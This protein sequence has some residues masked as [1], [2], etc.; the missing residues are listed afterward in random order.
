MVWSEHLARVNANLEGVREVVDRLVR[1]LVYIV[2][3]GLT[4]LGTGTVFVLVTDSLSEVTLESAIW[5]MA[6]GVPGLVFLR[7]GQRLTA[8]VFK[9]VLSRRLEAVSARITG[10][11]LAAQ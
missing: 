2:S 8:I 3:V 1:K 7:L 4:L 5:S 10:Q 6:G 11:S 9:R